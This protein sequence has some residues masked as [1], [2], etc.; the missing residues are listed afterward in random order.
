MCACARSAV[1]VS[2]LSLYSQVHCSVY[3]HVCSTSWDEQAKIYL[4]VICEVSHSSWSFWS[5]Q[6]RDGL[7]CLINFCLLWKKRKS[8]TEVNQEYRGSN[9]K[10]K[11]TKM[12]MSQEMICHRASVLFCY[13]PKCV[14]STEYCKLSRTES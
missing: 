2:A 13:G 5:P 3:M 6:E 4:F 1:F 9:N 10:I 14:I 8:M 11:G 12:I 7:R